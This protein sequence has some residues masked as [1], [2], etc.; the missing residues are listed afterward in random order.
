MMIKKTTTHRHRQVRDRFV[1]A[2]CALLLLSSCYETKRIPEDDHLYKGIKELAYGKQMKRVNNQSTETGVIT[3]VA[4]AYDA[5]NDILRGDGNLMGLLQMQ[6]SVLT[7][8]QRDSIALRI[9]QDQ[10]TYDRVK[11]EIEGVLSYPP[12]GSI[13]GSSK[14]VMPIIPRLWIWNRYVGSKSRFGKWMFNSFSTTPKLMSSV[15]P[16]V[17]CTVAK[18]TLHNFGYFHGSVSYEIVQMKNPRKQKISYQVLPGRLWHLDNVDYSDF[19]GHA[20]SIINASDSKKLL[21]TGDPFSAA[22][23]ASERSRIVDMMRNNGYYNMQE[24]HI[25]FRADTVQKPYLVQ[26]KLKPTTDEEI[27]RRYYLGNTRIVIYDHDKKEITDSLGFGTLKM[28]FSGGK[29]RTEKKYPQSPLRLRAMLPYLFYK[30]G[31]LYRK[32]RMEKIQELISGMGVFSSMRMDYA[33]RDSDTLDVIITAHLDKP[34]NSEFEGR[35]TSKS[36]GQIGPGLSYSID[37]KNAFRGAE[38]LTFGVNGSYEWQT[39]ANMQGD[40]SLLNSWEL[41]ANLTLS[42]PRFM[43]F[44][45][46]PRM[47][48][49]MKTTTYFKVDAKW[50]NRAAYFSRFNLGVRAVWTFQPRRNVTHEFTPIRLQYDRQLSTTERFDSIIHAN[51]ALYVSMRDQ[52]IP[53]MEYNFSWTTP[54]IRHTQAGITTNRRLTHTVTVNVKEAGNFVSCI[55]AI[56]GQSISKPGKELFGVP[57]AQ[58]IKGSVEYT[59]KMHITERQQFLMRSYLGLLYTYGNS[60]GAPYND[61]FTAGGANSIRAFGV[62][63]IGPGSYHP[64]YSGFS[65]LT[66]MGDMRFEANLEYRFPIVGNLFGAVFLDAGNVWLLEDDPQR[67]GG[68]FSFSNFAKDLALGTG[69]GVRYDMDFLVIRFDVGVGLHAPYDTGVSGYYNMPSF[70]RSLGYHFAIGYPF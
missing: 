40:K 41:G 49:R 29:A 26:L 39:G 53:S 8:E 31:D 20:D 25:T 70:G 52:F 38:T 45:W 37:K 14:V 22:D 1:V 23:L 57:F 61:L 65:Y 51:P 36:N 66:Q 48:R 12:N 46:S 19:T 7:K 5:V 44:G 30:K 21:H 6:D 4:N 11:S 10:E 27:L 33:K 2:I 54:S 28:I 16:D 60:T 42:Y 55:Y 13:M 56:A 62:R 15:S 34:Y 3:A 64:G 35:V 59:L 68:K 43:F 18:N 24:S 32:N 9:K 58:F 63:S 67:P 50:Q 69:F 17:R 47:S